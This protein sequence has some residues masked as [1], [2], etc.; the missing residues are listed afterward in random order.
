MLPKMPAGAARG[1]LVAG[2]GWRS[3]AARQAA[4]AGTPY[5]DGGMR[6]GESP[7]QLAKLAASI[8]GHLLRLVRSKDPA[9][10]ATDKLY[11]ARSRLAGWLVNRTR[12]YRSQI[13]QVNM[14]LKMDI[15]KEEKKKK[16]NGYPEIIR[17]KRT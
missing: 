12:L 17:R 8:G 15:Q 14:R 13:L 11:K 16:E 4:R 9:A 3:A 7:G 5:G 2:L 1:P 6:E 10:R